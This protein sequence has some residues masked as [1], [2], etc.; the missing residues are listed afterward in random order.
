MIST[1]NTEKAKELI[2][3]A[4]KPVI[5]QAQNDEFNRK[6]LEYGKFD[7]LLSPEKGK[8]GRTLRQID[9]GFNHVLARIA[10]KNKIALGI[11]AE[12]LRKLPKEEKALRIERVIQNIKLCRKAKTKLKLLNFK[13]KRDALALLTSLGASSQQAKQAV[14]QT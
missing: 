2:K 13:D 6:M 7:T 14:T 3:K 5:L 12:E 11:D 10:T 1:S 8:R 9:S 4:K